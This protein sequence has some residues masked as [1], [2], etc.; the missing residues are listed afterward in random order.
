MITVITCSKMSSFESKL[1][2]MYKFDGATLPVDHYESSLWFTQEHIPS[3]HDVRARGESTVRG[4][5]IM[6]NSHNP[7][8]RICLGFSL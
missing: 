7:P 6:A 2:Q 4:Y 5:D 3:I 1:M 8:Y